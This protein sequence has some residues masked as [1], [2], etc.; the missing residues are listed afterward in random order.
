MA[1]EHLNHKLT[2]DEQREGGKKSGEVRKRKAS[3]KKALKWLL[4]ESD[5]K[6]DKGAIFEEYKACGIDISQLTLEE[7]ATLGCFKGAIQGNASNYKTLVEVN[8]E[9]EVENTINTPPLRIEIV[10]DNPDL[11]KAMYDANEE[12]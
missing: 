9:L 7:L 4:E 11:E 12:D 5:F 3:F 2:L 1:V 10:E 6:L 8:G